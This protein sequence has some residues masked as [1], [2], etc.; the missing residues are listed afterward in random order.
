[1]V[2]NIALLLT[3]YERFGSVGMDEFKQLY[4]DEYLDMSTYYIGDYN[5]YL[6]EEGYEIYWND[7]EEM[8][9]GFNPLEVA[10]MTFYGDFSFAAD[11]HKFNGYANIDSFEEY[12]VLNKMTS[13]D[14]FKD[15]LIDRDGFDGFDDEEIE[16]IIEEANKLIKEGY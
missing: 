11:Y 8:L 3:Q 15:W 4:K 10:R 1:M 2:K 14:G 12:Q 13:D 9:Q 5:E 16:E 7:L 6:S